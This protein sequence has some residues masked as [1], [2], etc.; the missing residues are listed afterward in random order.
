MLL[1][2]PFCRKQHAVDA[3]NLPP[4]ATSAIC[5][6][7]H[8]RFPLPR[9]G[10]TPRQPQSGHAATGR[11]VD[12]FQR[13][14]FALNPLKQQTENDP[15]A[16]TAPVAP[17]PSPDARRPDAAAAPAPGAAAPSQAGR[18]APEAADTAAPEDATHTAVPEGAP[19]MAAGPEPAAGPARAAAADEERQRREAARA[20]EDIKKSLSAQ[21]ENG[22][23]TAPPTPRFV[24]R[25]RSIAVMISKGGVGKTTTAVNLAA[26]LALL[27]RRTLLVDTDTQGQAAYVLG[28][29]AATG[30]AEVAQG[31]LSPAEAVIRARDNLYLLAGGKALAGVKRLISRK[32]FGGERTLSEVLS[33]LLADYDFMIVDS[34]PGWDPLT[35]NVMFLVREVIVPVS[36]EALALQGLVEFLRSFQAIAAYNQRLRLSAIVPT[37]LDRRVRQPLAL[38]RELKALYPDLVAPP[39]RYNV[40][41]SEAPARGQTIFEYAPKSPGAEDYMAL[42]RSVAGL[43]GQ[44]GTAVETAELAV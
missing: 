39:V 7:C 13:P 18:A 20:L 41:L 6:G 21:V 15:A 2:C 16:C 35:V 24:E 28:V 30:L 8:R 9:A 38:Y 32:D 17:E 19:D 37:F 12:M 11:V 23:R 34:S 36:L 33:P 42:V 26:G 1:I 25:A 14:R 31:D 22:P 29:K 40:K 4:T 10:E 3:A 27:G 43:E 44:G 5:Q